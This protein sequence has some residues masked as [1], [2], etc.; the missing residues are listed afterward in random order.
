MLLYSYTTAIAGEVTIYRG[1]PKGGASGWFIR[2][3]VYVDGKLIGGFRQFDSAKITLQPG[4]HLFRLRDD[5]DSVWMF[6]VTGDHIIRFSPGQ[7]QAEWSEVDP[8][9]DP[10]IA[11]ELTQTKALA[12]PTPDDS[13]K[14]ER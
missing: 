14:T 9:L 13:H 3:E 12:S 7:S 4:K 2:F 8:N 11:S 6:Q 5:P 1:R 10:M